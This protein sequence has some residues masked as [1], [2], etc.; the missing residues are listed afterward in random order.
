MLTGVTDQL[1][2]YHSPTLAPGKYYVV[3]TNEVFDAT[4]ESIGRLW[5]AR[6]HFQEIEL[7]PKGSAQATLQ[8]VT[9][10]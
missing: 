7:A 3:A 6:N 8:P 2:T 5:R 10:E 9:I 1:G 4:P